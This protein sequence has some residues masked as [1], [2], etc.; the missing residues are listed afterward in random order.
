MALEAGKPVIPIA[1][2]VSGENLPGFL[3]SK[4]AVFCESNQLAKCVDEAVE[5][6]SSEQLP[7]S[8]VSRISIG[9][10]IFALLCLVGLSWAIVWIF[11]GTE[12]SPIGTLI[13]LGIG[14]A[15]AFEKG[16][17]GSWDT[18]RAVCWVRPKIPQLLIGGLCFVPAAFGLGLSLTW[19]PMLSEIYF[20]SYLT[21]APVVAVET[22]SL[23][24]IGAFFFNHPTNSLREMRLDVLSSI[25]HYGKSWKVYSFAIILLALCVSTAP[26][27]SHFVLF[28]PKV[29][30]VETRYVTDGQYHIYQ[31][32]LTSFGAWSQN[33]KI[34]H[35]ITPL[36][37][38]ITEGAY[39]FVT[40][41]TTTSPSII[42]ESG[43]TAYTPSEDSQGRV[44]I[45]LSTDSMSGTE[46]Q[47]SVQFYS[48]FDVKTLAYIYLSPGTFIQNFKNGTQQRERQFVVVNH[49][50]Y[51]LALNNVILY[52][53]G[54]RA[55]NV[56]LKFY[57]N[58]PWPTYHYSND[59][60]SNDTRSFYLS[61]TVQM[62]GNLTANVIY[63]SP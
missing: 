24:V 54:Y 58:S 39:S 42:S 14:G 55:E 50:Q 43:L 8:V 53:D 5:P 38:L 15:I 48:E 47:F 27:D 56:S 63:N 10:V 23:L 1:F 21:K 57:A 59:L 44:L 37:P 20:E 29:S 32:G 46:A 16:I 52:S 40:N 25:R 28:T 45:G 12:L 62:Y 13:G 60:Y 4:Q 49:S 33:E 2:G 11:T 7:E 26:V 51:D 6:F 34:I 18:M 36:L 19:Y 17:K 9:L 31:I 30:L 3:K 35:V 41:S 61:T 22:F